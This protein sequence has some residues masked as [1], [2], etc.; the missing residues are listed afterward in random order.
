MGIPPLSETIGIMSHAAYVYDVN[1]IIIDNLQFMVGHSDKISDK[2]LLLQ[3]QAT[4]AF[5]RFASEHN[6]HLTLVSH[7]RKEKEDML[8]INSLYGSVRVGQEADNILALQYPSVNNSQ[9]RRY[10]QVLKNRYDGTLG[11]FVLN[12]DRTTLSYTLEPVNTGVQ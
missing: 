9:N 7:P 12:F 5:R 11:Q 1:H 6:C 10:L 2:L 4:T 3:D 8:T